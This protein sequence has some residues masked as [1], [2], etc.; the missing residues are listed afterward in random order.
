MKYRVRDTGQPTH[1]RWTA[2]NET[3][4][5]RSNVIESMAQALQI[6]RGHTHLFALLA[7]LLVFSLSFSSLSL[8]FDSDRYG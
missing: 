3:R 2:E 4:L 8:S 6:E 1:K 7:R 5:A